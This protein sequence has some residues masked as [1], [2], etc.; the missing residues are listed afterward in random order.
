MKIHRSIT[1]PIRPFV[2]MGHRWRGPDIGLIWCWENGRLLAQENPAL[3]LQA[4]NGE[5]IPLVWKGGVP[6]DFKSKRKPGA[7]NYLAQWQGLAGKDLNIDIGA[8][9]TLICSKTGVKVK[10]SKDGWRNDEQIYCARCR[11][12]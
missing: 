11:N 2:D 3:A 9:T 12:G 6:P 5:L 4:Q 7:L 1:E 10:F 8:P